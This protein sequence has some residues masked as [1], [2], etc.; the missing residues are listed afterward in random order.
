[1]L[2]C[3]HDP[4]ELGKLY[5]EGQSKLKMETDAARRSRHL[6][7]LNSVPFD[8]TSQVLLDTCLIEQDANVGTNTTRFGQRISQQT[9]LKKMLNREA[10]Q[11]SSFFFQ[12]S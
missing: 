12:M 3:P 10:R 6:L 8:Q 5:L 11:Q 7:V 4:V 1:M 9:V 2:P